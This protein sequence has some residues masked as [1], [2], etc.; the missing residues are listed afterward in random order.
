MLP[1]FRACEAE[2]RIKTKKEAREFKSEVQQ[3]DVGSKT[4]RSR[5]RFALAGAFEGTT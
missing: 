1:K 2:S 4:R 5:E 3:P